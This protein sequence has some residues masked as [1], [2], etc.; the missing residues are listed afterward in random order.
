M[1]I[2]DLFPSIYLPEDPIHPSRE[3][4]CL[5]CPKDWLLCGSKCYRFFDEMLKDWNKSHE[6]CSEKQA[7]LLVLQD[8][9]EQVKFEVTEQAGGSRVGVETLKWDFR[10]SQQ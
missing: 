10:V 3:K 2:T 5:L 7:Q 8:Q 6:N 9:E 4:Q 1:T